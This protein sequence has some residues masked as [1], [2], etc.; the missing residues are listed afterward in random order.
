MDAF[1]KPIRRRTF[2]SG[3]G[4]L[5]LGL[6][7]GGALSAMHDASSARAAGGHITVGVNAISQPPMQPYLAEFKK[8]I[9]ISVQLLAIPTSGGDILAQLVPEFASGSSPFDV[10]DAAD[11]VAPTFARAGWLDPIDDAVGPGFWTDFPQSMIDYVKTWG[12]VGSKRYKIPRSFDFSYYFVRKDVLDKLGAPVPASWDD[13]LAL[14]PKA[15]KLG[16]YAFGD[17]VSKPSISFVYISNLAA[18]AG[19]KVFEF[20]QGT[21]EAFLFAKQLIDKKFFPREAIQW[22]YDQSNAAYMNNKLLTMR[23]WAFFYDVSR[24]NKSWFTPDKVVIAL[25]LK[26]PT[27]AATW[28]GG[29]GWTLP[30]FSK[31]KQQAKAFLRFITSN[32]VSARLAKDSALFYT[33]RY[34]TLKYLNNAGLAKDLSDYIQANV[35]VPRPFHPNPGEAQAAVDTAITGYLSGQLSLQQ[36][37]DQGKKQIAALG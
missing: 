31:N 15:Q 2:I 8:Q 6:S 27:R 34:S 33:P 1:D 37:L 26:G 21:R 12:S 19:G 10:L 22:T 18:Q 23:Q 9:G 16:M 7:V 36:A 3:A 29:M 28:V 25:P 17:A 35:I 14:G 13:I 5:G 32:S 4:S 30:K 11:E 20:D 24:A